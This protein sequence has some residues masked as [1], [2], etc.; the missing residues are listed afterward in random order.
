MLSNAE[1]TSVASITGRLAAGTDHRLAGIAELPD[2]V[3]ADITGSA[4][5]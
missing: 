4:C 2:R 3:A 1:A 5:D